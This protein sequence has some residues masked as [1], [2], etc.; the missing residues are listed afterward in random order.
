MLSRVKVVEVNIFCPNL[1]FQ[2]VWYGLVWF[3]NFF[4]PV[5]VKPQHVRHQLGLLFQDK[6]DGEL[7]LP[8]QPRKKCS[9]LRYTP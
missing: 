2:L 4:G 3:G 6:S 9:K 1:N 7:K 8:V 5:E